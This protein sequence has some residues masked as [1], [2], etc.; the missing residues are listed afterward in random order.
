MVLKKYFIIFL[1]EGFMK[2]FGLLFSIIILVS[3]LAW[4]QSTGDYRSK[5]SGNWNN[6]SSWETY[7]SPNW[8]APASVPSSASGVITILNGHVI[9]VASSDVTVDQMTINSGGQ[10]TIALARTMTIANGIGTDLTVNGLLINAGTITRIGSIIFESGSTYQHQKNGGTIPT[11]TWNSNSTCLITG[12]TSTLPSGMGQTFGHLTWN[13]TGQSTSDPLGSLFTV[14]GN[15]TLIS[16]GSSSQLQLASGTTNITGNYSQTGGSIRLGSNPTRTLNVSGNFSIT[17]GTFVVTDDLI[18][19]LNVAGNFTHTAGST[20]TETG[21]SGNIVFNGSGI[22]N[23]TGGG[24]ISN[25]INFT[26]NNPAGIILLS[27]ATFPAALTMT[28]GNITTGIY[29]LSLGTSTSNRGTLS[30]TSGTI[31]GNFR[32]WFSAG[33]ISNVLFP[34]GTSTYYRPA[35]I[36][37]TSAP[38]SGG[39]LTSFF[40][41]SDPGTNGLPLS[42][43]GTSIITAGKEG[44]WTI[45]AGD[46]LSGGVYSLDLIA[47][48]FT[49]VSVVSSLRLLKRATLGNWTLNGT[50][51]N[52]TGTISTPVVHRTGLS[53]FSEFGVGGASDNP[54]PVELSSFSASIIGSA[55]KLSWKT[56]TETNNFGFE[57]LRSAQND[58]DWIK[59]GFVDGYGNSNS[60]KDYSFTDASVVSGSYSYRLKQIDIDGQFDYSK[61]IEVELGAPKK[62]ELA[63][64]FPNPFN[65][66]TSISFTLPESGNVKLTVYNLLGQEIAIL[67]N[68]VKEAGTHIINFNVEELNSGIYIYKIEAGNFVQTKKMTLIK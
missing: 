25:T 42:D 4:G 55:V 5:Q 36:S 21:T 17:G 52:G 7:V 68:G 57:I 9:A 59:L 45:N 12:I 22:Q 16:T 6:L 13:C 11:A 40:T 44:Y 29:T 15:F 2:K 66:N 54:L 32:R 27:S 38:T 23:Y 33:T 26:I 31:I 20:I 35:N 39:T 60:P 30:R 65:P 58:N 10:V 18:S 37:F 14:A 3:Q 51:S 24:T 48:G 8:V 67:V 63:Q 46:G 49:G 56:E 28:N 43:G 64:N 53:S 19:T 1:R 62:Y 34:I 61:I 41:E 47:D 50:H